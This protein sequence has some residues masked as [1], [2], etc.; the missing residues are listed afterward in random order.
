M[1]CAALILGSLLYYAVGPAAATHSWTDVSFAVM[2]RLSKALVG[3]VFGAVFGAIL[4]GLLYGRTGAVACS[5]VAT[6]ISAL[7]YSSDW[8]QMASWLATASIGM[9]TTIV[10]G[11][12][13]VLSRSWG[14]YVF[15]TL[16]LGV[17][18]DFPWHAMQ[19]LEDAHR[20]GVLRQSGR[21][22]QFRHEHLRK[23]LAADEKAEPETVDCPRE[24][25][26]DSSAA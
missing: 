17:H 23:Y 11:C 10:M 20:R 19:F 26:P 9:A 6:C 14:A 22:Y 25:Q 5:V 3:G 8:T 16:C 24:S 12:L 13:V 15:A 4:G 7:S 1:L 18:D 2:P 21:V